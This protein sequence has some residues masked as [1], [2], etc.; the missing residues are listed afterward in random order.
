MTNQ[1][2]TKMNGLDL[3]LE[4]LSRPCQP[5]RHIRHLIS[6]KRL[7]IEVC[8]QRTTNWSVDDVMCLWKVKLVTSICLERNILKQLEMLF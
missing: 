3:C 6:R 4:V 7:E 8:F 1:L 2:G 5:L